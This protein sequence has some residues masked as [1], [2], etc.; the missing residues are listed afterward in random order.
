M[1]SRSLPLQQSLYSCYLLEDKKCC[2]YQHGYC[3]FLT[4]KYWLLSDVGLLKSRPL[5]YILNADSHVD[6]KY[7]LTVKISYVTH[8]GIMWGKGGHSI[9]RAAKQTSAVA[10]PVCA[11]L[12]LH[13]ALTLRIKAPPLVSIY[14]VYT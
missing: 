8:T 3:R 10:L 9:S 4:L 13:A 11:W 14:Q 12:F 7:N 5:N 1:E 2:G 6:K